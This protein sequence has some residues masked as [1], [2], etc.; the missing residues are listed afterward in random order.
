MA[1]DAKPRI[2]Q[3]H[4]FN[5]RSLAVTDPLFLRRSSIPAT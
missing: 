5:P 3:Q 1:S 2:L 4:S